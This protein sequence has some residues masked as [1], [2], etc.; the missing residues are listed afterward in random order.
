MLHA[1]DSLTTA[2]VELTHALIYFYWRADFPFEPTA[3][4]ITK[5]YSS[6]DSF[7]ASLLLIRPRVTPRC[8]QSSQV[9]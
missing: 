1:P 4:L 5:P 7:L 6:N 2:R 3:T 8:V 9:S